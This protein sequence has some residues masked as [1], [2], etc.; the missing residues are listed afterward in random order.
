MSSC[1]S[2]NYAN[3]RGELSL[4][5]EDDFSPESYVLNRLRPVEEEEEVRN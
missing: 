4:F 3:A 5:E 2:P 1:D